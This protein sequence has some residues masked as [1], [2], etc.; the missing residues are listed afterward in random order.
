MRLID[1][2]CTDEIDEAILNAVA[3]R[4]YRTGILIECELYTDAFIVK[5]PILCDSP[6]TTDRCMISL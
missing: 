2:I 4:D 6:S 5:N 3:H 1:K